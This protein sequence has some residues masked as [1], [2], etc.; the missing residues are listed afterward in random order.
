MRWANSIASDADR[1]AGIYAERILNGSQ[2]SPRAC[3]ENHKTSRE[4]VE[5]MESD[6]SPSKSA[7]RPT[8]MTVRSS[9]H[10]DEGCVGLA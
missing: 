2:A 4:A 10:S 8:L 6:L 3:V 1:Q 5:W 7:R 9:K